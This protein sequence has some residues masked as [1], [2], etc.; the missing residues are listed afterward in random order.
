[1][2]AHIEWLDANHTSVDL[3]PGGHRIDGEHATDDD[4]DGSVITDELAL[5]F[6]ADDVVVLH[7]THQHLRHLVDNLSRLLDSPGASHTR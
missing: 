5:V 2:S 3:V 6:V 4:P 1:M 7:G